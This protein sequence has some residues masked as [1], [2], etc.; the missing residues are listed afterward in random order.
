MKTFGKFQRF[1]RVK[2]IDMIFSDH[3]RFKRE[4][5]NRRL[6][7]EPWKLNTTFLN[8]AWG[9]EKGKGENKKYFELSGKKNEHMKIC[10]MQRKQSLEGNFP[11]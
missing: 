2:V 1:K 7:G 9:K 6:S 5:N 11:H 8:N 3:R 4:I 10:G